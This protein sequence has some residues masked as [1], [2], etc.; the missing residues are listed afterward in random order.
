MI[1]VRPAVPADDR[2]LLGIDAETW[3]TAVTPAPRRPERHRFFAA[4]EVPSDVLVAERDGQVVGYVRLN[5]AIRLPSHRHVLEVNGLAVAPHAQGGGVGRALVE[6]A[7]H[8][9]GHRG[10]SKLTLRVLGGNTG[11]RRLYESCGFVVEG[12]LTGEFRLAG[13]LVDDV[14]MACSLG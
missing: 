13:E 11:A 2:V 12:V 9:A 6:C 7:K 5:Q 1:E 10:A 4:E 14:L 8:E 3:S